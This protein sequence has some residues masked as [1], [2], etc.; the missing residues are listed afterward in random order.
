[1]KLPLISLM[2]VLYTVMAA[3]WLCYADLNLF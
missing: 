1:M 3:I 2:V